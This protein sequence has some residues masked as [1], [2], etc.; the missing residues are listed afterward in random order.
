MYKGHFASV[1]ALIGKIAASVGNSYHTHIHNHTQIIKK[2]EAN[3]QS[4]ADEENS[5][6]PPKK[7]Q[8][9]CKLKIN[10]CII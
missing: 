9:I 1:P 2:S 5:R 8:F 6:N 4:P 7:T 10:N 3:K